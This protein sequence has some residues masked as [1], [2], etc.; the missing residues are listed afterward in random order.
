MVDTMEKQADN[1]AGLEKVKKERELTF[2][3]FLKDIPLDLL[4]TFLRGQAIIYRTY[5]LPI[6]RL[7]K[8]FVRRLRAHW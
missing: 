6:E 7:F 3:E 1:S 8:R 2:L 5:C 4:H